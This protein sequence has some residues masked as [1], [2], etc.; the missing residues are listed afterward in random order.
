MRRKAH[1]RFRFFLAAHGIL[2]SQEGEWTLEFHLK[3]F[4]CP[5]PVTESLSPEPLWPVPDSGFAPTGHTGPGYKVSRRDSVD[6]C[7]Q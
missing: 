5:G 2:A 3:R 7:R 6:G 1:P 4:H